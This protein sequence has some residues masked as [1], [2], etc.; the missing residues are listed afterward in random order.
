MDQKLKE[1]LISILFITVVLA[2]LYIWLSPQKQADKLEVPENIKP[3]LEQS[4]IDFDNP[5]HRALLKD[6]LLIYGPDKSSVH[7]SLIK[8]VDEYRQQLV[9][10]AVVSRGRGIGFFTFLGMY[11]K[12]IFIYV[13]VMLITYYGVQSL[14][15]FRFVRGKRGKTSYLKEVIDLIKNKPVLR[16][17]EERLRFSGHILEKVSKMFLMGMA[18]LLL[19]TPAYVVA[20][21]IKTDFNT[22]SN[23][24]IIL[25]AVITNGLLITYTYK[26]YTF[27]TSES[28]KGYVLTAR[29]KNLNNDY[30]KNSIPES[31]IFAFR[32]YFGGHVFHHIYINARFQYISALKEQASFLISGLI[33]IE[34]ALNIHGHLSYELLRQLLYKNYDAVI[35]IL[36]GIFY[37]VK[38]TEIFTDWLQDRAERK[39]AD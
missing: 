12:F 8:S 2:G 18:Y 26:F 30:S 28:K 17:W 32:K 15:V 13:I 35:I 11:F 4:F 33:I 20:Y 9:E 1:H 7:N 31:S 19:F 29:V 16:N 10:S 23:I 14:A 22:S 21:S 34:M 39:I 5:F 25:L 27:L 6:L 24:F 36:A 37:L 3:Y 38:A